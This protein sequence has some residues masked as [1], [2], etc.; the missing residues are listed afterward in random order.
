MAT[1]GCKEEADVLEKMEI[2]EDEDSMVGSAEI[3]NHSTSISTASENVFPK[4]EMK[5]TETVKSMDIREMLTEQ[6]R[7]EKVGMILPCAPTKVEG[8][9]FADLAI[10]LL[11]GLR[12]TIDK[13]LIMLKGGV[14]ETS[15]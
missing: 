8:E 7:I 14:I 1:D 5:K 10:Q 13:L 3:L 2:S 6:L 12:D 15:A 11:G 9:K 4:Q